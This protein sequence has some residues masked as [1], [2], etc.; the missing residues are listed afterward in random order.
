VFRH[1]DIPASSSPP[2]IACCRSR[3]CRRPGG[4]SAVLDHH[5]LRLVL[6]AAARP[7]PVG[8]SCC[9]ERQNGGAI[10]IGCTADPCAVEP[11]CRR[12]ERPAGPFL[13][14]NCT[15]REAC[16]AGGGTQRPAVA[17]STPPAPCRDSS[18]ENL[19]TI[20]RRKRP[21]HSRWR[22]T[23]SIQDRHA[24]RHERRGRGRYAPA[25]AAHTP[26][27]LC[28]ACHASA[29]R[30]GASAASAGTATSGLPSNGERRRHR[31]R[32][33]GTGRW[34]RRGS[35]LTPHTSENASRARTIVRIVWARLAAWGLV[36]S[37]M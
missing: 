13:D 35:W 24:I 37:V 8:S 3:G 11:G 15:L 18:N 27:N 2:R 19:A 32:S 30:L 16:V 10:P 12:P 33:S 28:A 14:G 25:R 1:G 6:S 36:I 5:R 9:L 20:H 7:P 26:R 4:M 31:R 34:D 23:S 22:P 21:A 29:S 17:V